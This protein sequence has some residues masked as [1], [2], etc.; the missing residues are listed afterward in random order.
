MKIITLQDLQ[1][2][3]GKNPKAKRYFRGRWAYISV[4][5]NIVRRE[6]PQSILEIGATDR[7]IA[8]GCDTM[9]RTDNGKPF[10]LTYAHDATRIPWP[11]PSVFYDLV[12][13]M[14]VFEHL[15]NSQQQV[16]QEI[17]RVSHSVILTFPDRWDCP[18]DCHH[19]I[20]H[21]IIQGWASRLE[22]CEIIRVSGKRVI[23]F[24][25]FDKCL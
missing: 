19:G 10:S 1:Q 12:I 7:P 17:K 15:G 4:V 13:A 16:F 8:L 23:Y 9:D 18:G 21:A 24:W 20:T 6:S 25:R 14:Q 5:A 22:P 11:I 3:Q 2:I